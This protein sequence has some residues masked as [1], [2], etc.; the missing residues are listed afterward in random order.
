MRDLNRRCFPQ[1]SA[2]V[3]MLI[4]AVSAS[5]DEPKEQAA[6]SNLTGEQIYRKQCIGCHGEAGK[7]SKKYKKSLTGDL[8]VGQLTKLI[9]ETMPEENPDECVGEDARKVAEFIMRAFIRPQ[10]RL[11]TSRRA[12]RW[13]G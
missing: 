2:L 13:C 6:G 3:L 7:G 4:F 1:V 5:A 10:R 8:S 12:W 11:A 9:D